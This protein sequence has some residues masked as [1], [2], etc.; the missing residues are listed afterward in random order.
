M[1]N[2]TNSDNNT[3]LAPGSVKAMA[4]AIQERALAPPSSRPR[5]TAMILAQQ[6]IDEIVDNDLVPGTPL[7][8]EAEMVARYDVAR[9]TLRETLRFLEMQGVVKIKTGPG[10]GPVVAD[11]GSQPLASVIALLL[12]LSHTSYGSIVDARMELEP[13]LARKA[14]ENRTEEHLEVLQQSIEDMRATMENAKVFLAHNEVFHT[15]VARAA[16][17]PV[18]FHMAAS[19]AWIDDGT[20]VGINYS[21]DTRE[22]IIKHHKQIYKAIE[23]QDGDLAEAA[24]RLH[25]GDF[26]RHAEAKFAMVLS[27]PL[28]WEQVAR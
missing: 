10:G 1:T 28:R 18:L 21:A 22:P 27:Q 11:P 25:I 26:A 15:T 2:T 6:I 13:M 20:V 19:L 3:D 24:M 4:A 14:A 16:G 7:L 17:N 23:A 5:K 12:Q 9:G 8:S